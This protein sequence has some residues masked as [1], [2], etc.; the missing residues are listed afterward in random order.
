MGTDEFAIPSL[1]TLFKSKHELIGIITQPDR[2]SGRG[3]KLRASPVKKLTDKLSIPLYQ[4]KRVSNSNF[5]EKIHKLEPELIIVVAY[6]QLLKKNV[7]CCP[8]V[9]CVNVHPSLLPKYRGAA[10]IQRAIING[11]KQ[12]GITIMLMD[13]GEDTGDIITQKTVEIEHED[14]SISL[15]DKL[16][17]IAAEMLLEVVDQASKKEDLRHTPQVHDEATYAPKITRKDGKI[18]WSESAESIYNLVRGTLPWPGA[19]TYY[20]GKMV[21]IISCEIAES[22]LEEDEPGTITVKSKKEIEVATGDGK[23]I[24]NGLQPANKRKMRARDFINGY[25]LKTGVCFGTE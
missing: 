7:L 9:A 10:P 18:D 1:L 13:E 12:T 22:D 25:R 24:I 11:E 19:Y 16:S 15:K 8:S 20:N 23:L 14:S 21:K 3:R 4:P 2:P 17:K 5:V 6:G